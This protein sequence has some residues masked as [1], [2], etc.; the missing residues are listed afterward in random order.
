MSEGYE[1]P[2]SYR[3]D[4]PRVLQSFQSPNASVKYNGG[5]LSDIILLTRRCDYIE[6]CMAINVSVQY[7]CMYVCCMVITYS[8]VWTNRVRLPILLVV[9]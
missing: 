6:E 3:G 1:V 5:L 9:S 7:V 2:L 4:R 8:R